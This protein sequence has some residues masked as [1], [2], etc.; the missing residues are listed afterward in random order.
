ML[1]R[2]Q[3]K[4]MRL[5]VAAIRFRPADQTDRTLV[6]GFFFFFF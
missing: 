2:T 5:N 1:D 6:A 4:P 3:S